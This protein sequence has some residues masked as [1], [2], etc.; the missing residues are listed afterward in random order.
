[1]KRFAIRKGN[2]KRDNI[3]QRTAA[4]SG[5]FEFNSEVAKVF[6]DMLVRSVPFYHEQQHMIAEI[7]GKFWIPGT[8]VYD[9]GCST[10]TTLI[11]ICQKIK[12]SERF[13]GYDNS[14]PMLREAKRKIKAF[15]LENRI[16]LHNCDLNKELSKLSLKNARVVTLCWTLQ[17]VRP[18]QRESLIKKIYRDLV[19]DGILLITEKVLTNNT[20]MNRFFIDL[21]YDFKK[22]NRYSSEEIQRKREALDNVLVPY[23]IDENIELFRRNG[24]EIVEIFFQWYNFVGVLCLK[25]PL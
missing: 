16:Q 5:D 8:K 7:A 13:I 18:L 25:K 17:F 22:R 24:F 23:R 10:G 20:D 6:D 9:L 19:D 15:G 12:G 14:E 11:N 3:F 4:R 1:V 21:Y 2:M